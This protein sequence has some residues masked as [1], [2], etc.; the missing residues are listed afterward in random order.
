MGA[1][2]WICRSLAATKDTWATTV[3]G[4]CSRLSLLDQITEGGDSFLYLQY[5]YF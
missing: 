2:D 4:G 1:K 3:H 5:L